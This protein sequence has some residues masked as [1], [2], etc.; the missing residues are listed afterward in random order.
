M[1]KLLLKKNGYLQVHN[2]G[3][4]RN[5]LNWTHSPSVKMKFMNNKQQKKFLQATCC[6]R[7]KIDKIQSAP[8]ACTHSDQYASPCSR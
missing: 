5:F 2:I 6:R 8:T 7:P 3:T 1:A 4:W